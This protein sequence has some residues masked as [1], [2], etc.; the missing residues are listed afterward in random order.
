MI[1]MMPTGIFFLFNLIKQDILYFPSKPSERV[2]YDH[3]LNVTPV[4][5]NNYNSPVSIL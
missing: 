2:I 5:T 3:W 4:P 1:N